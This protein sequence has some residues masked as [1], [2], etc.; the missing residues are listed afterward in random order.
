MNVFVTTGFIFSK[1]CVSRDA[2]GEDDYLTVAGLY[3][4]SLAKI[5]LS[6]P[7]DSY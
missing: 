5:V 1:T 4:V 6:R 2:E 7:W 3:H